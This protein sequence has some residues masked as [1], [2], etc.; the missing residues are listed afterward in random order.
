MGWRL[1]VVKGGLDDVVV[2]MRKVLAEAFSTVGVG[3]RAL[4]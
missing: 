2:G 1:R 4:V 3:S